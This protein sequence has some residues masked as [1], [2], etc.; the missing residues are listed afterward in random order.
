MGKR[1][2][3][4]YQGGGYLA[5][6]VTVAHFTPIIMTNFHYHYIHVFKRIE[7]Q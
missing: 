5:P 6:Y 1:G 4:V 2:K 3:D 7:T